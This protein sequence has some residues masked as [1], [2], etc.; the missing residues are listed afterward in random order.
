MARFAFIQK[1]APCAASLIKE[2]KVNSFPTL[3]L[4]EAK[5][6]PKVIKF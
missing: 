6:N 1:D 3:L 4:K 2:L 5:E